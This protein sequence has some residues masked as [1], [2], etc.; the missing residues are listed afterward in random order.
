MLNITYVDYVINFLHLD[1][2]PNSFKTVN[3][4]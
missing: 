2:K 3:V 1:A 4:N